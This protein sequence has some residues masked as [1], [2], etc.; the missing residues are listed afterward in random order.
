MADPIKTPGTTANPAA[1][2]T[3]AAGTTTATTPGAT[4]TATGTTT[5]T[6]GAAYDAEAVRV[7]SAATTHDDKSATKGLIVGVLTFLALSL[8]EWLDGPADDA[9]TNAGA[10]LDSIT[11]PEM[12]IYAVVGIIVGVIVKAIDKARQKKAHA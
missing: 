2:T 1:N 5:G 12:A 7:S 4:T 6:T 3:T 9:G 8:W 11:F 10:A